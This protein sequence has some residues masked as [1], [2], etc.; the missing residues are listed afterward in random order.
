M[1]FDPV[2]FFIG[3]AVGIIFT[4]IVMGLLN[5]AK[6]RD[7]EMTI[8]TLKRKLLVSRLN[9]ELQDRQEGND[10]NKKHS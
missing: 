8:A 1:T 4:C 5:S 6:I 7:L 3:V 2:S 10:P 9:K